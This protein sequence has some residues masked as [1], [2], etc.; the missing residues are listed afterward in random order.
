MRKPFLTEDRLAA[1][2]VALLGLA[3]LLATRG[4]RAAWDLVPAVGLTTE[5]DDNARLLPTDQPTSTRTAL[6]ARLRMR[7][8]GDRGEAY[9]EPRFV[10]DAY[11]ASVD[12]PLES[13]D[14]FLLTSA[15]YQFEHSSI[16]FQT[17]YRKESVLRS[18]IDPALPDNLTD[19]GPGTVDTGAGTLGTFTDER[20]RLDVGFNVGFVLSPRTNMRLE[21]SRIDV[22][23]PDQVSVVRSP[24]DDNQIGVRLIRQVDQRNQVSARAYYDDFHAVRNDNNSNAFGVE[25]AFARPLSETWSVE[26]AMGVARTDYTFRPA[27]GGIVD[28]A[29]NNFTF[30]TAFRKRSQLTNWTIEVGRAIDP[31]SNGFLTVRDDLRLRMAH[32][33]TSRLAASF[34]LRGSQVD[35]PAES[36]GGGFTRDFWRASFQVDWNITPR[37]LL[38]TGID[39]VTEEFPQALGNAVS[40]ALL[41]GVRYQGLSQPGTRRPASLGPQPPLAP[42]LPQ[43]PPAR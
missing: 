10:T 35:T 1:I 34:G 4:A 22:G 37:W 42:Q 18:E 25:G 6:D 40:N 43:T 12:K 9:I 17:D 23:Y 28:N 41:V 14:V 36:V 24:F 13:N 20:K 2:G 16:D 39:H 21:L 15:A 38:T 32:Q 27:T 5:V 33:F 7:S 3:A 26:F 30:N 19:Q 31:N 29:A 11:S 8:F